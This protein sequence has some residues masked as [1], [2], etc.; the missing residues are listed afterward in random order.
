MGKDKY[1]NKLVLEQLT[2]WKGNFK[3]GF[4]LSAIY[5]YT[6]MQTLILSRLII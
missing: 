5:V 3:I 1:F 2:L 4:I 6:I